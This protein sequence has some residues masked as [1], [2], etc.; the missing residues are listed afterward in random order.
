M[1][2]SGIL[3]P[4]FSLPSKYGIG[5]FGKQAYEF[6]EFLEKAGQR[7]WQI[8]PLNPT[9]FGDSPYQSFS[10]AAGNP[11]FIDL[12]M[13]REDGLLELSDY[14]DV[15]FG[16][17]PN[18]VDYEKMYNNRMPVLR[19]ACSRFIPDEEWEI[20][21]A[22]EKYWLDE[23]AFFMALKDS[24]GGVSWRDWDT[25]FQMREPSVLA[26][27]KEELS[28]NIKFYKF[29]QFCFYKQWNKLK[30]FANEHGVLIIGDMPIYVADDSVDVWS[31]P[32]QFDLDDELLPRSV[33]GCPPDAFSEDGQL[34]GSPVYDWD[35]MKNESVP[36]SWWRTRMRHAFKV[37]DIVRI[38]HFRGFESFYCIPYGDTDAKGGKWRKGPGMELFN[39]LSEEFGEEL[40]I[41]AEDLGLL[42]DE[43]RQ[44]LDESGFPGMNVLQFAFDGGM[45]S[46]Y[47]PHNHRKNSIVYT[48]THDNDTIAGWVANADAGDVQRARRYLH[49]D[50]NEGF[51]WAMIRS[52]LMSVADTAIICMPDFMGL[53]SEARINAPS[54]LGGT[55]WQWRI[56]DG[57]INDWLAQI[58]RDNTALYGRLWV[59]EKN[60]NEDSEKKKISNE[61][62]SE[63]A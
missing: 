2:A 33:A 51:H 15:D 6:V 57:C 38:D 59:V 9:N 60:D 4:I 31:C 42:T 26:K 14:C 12:D 36:Y 22:Q 54:T 48:G 56:A 37:Y 1:R 61:G 16:S 30:K 23:Y 11:Y 35:Y 27:A 39:V 25:D 34:W 20:F 10:S 28:E 8:L 13:L 40:P 49:V 7:Y 45:K 18:R 63:P 52:A 32:K 41:I 3:M 46:S 44:L 21:C 24:F 50:D 19:T 43:V 53:S 62:V 58:I 5:T 29:I 55:N 47:L 17:D